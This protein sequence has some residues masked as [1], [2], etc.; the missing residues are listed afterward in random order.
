MLLR[1]ALSAFSK[2]WK[3][4]SMNLRAKLIGNQGVKT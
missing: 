3:F 2:A 4:I 1:A